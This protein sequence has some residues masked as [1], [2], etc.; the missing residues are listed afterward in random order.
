MYINVHKWNFIFQAKSSWKSTISHSRWLRTK[1]SSLCGKASLPTT[2]GWV[3][4]PSSPS[5]S[6]SR[7]LSLLKSYS[8]SLKSHSQCQPSRLSFI[9][10][11]S[12]LFCFQANMAYKKHVL[13][14]E[15]GSGGLWC[16]LVYTAPAI[17]QFISFCW[18]IC[19]DHES[20]YKHNTR[21]LKAIVLQ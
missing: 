20:W 18:Q 10:S 14:I 11:M 15:G 7:S 17:R 9:N 8:P 6:L 12:T 13:G 16:D 5:S 19:F 3:P 2:S 4:T 1:A 21:N